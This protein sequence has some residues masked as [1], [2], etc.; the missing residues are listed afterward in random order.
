MGSLTMLGRYELIAE[1]GKGAMGVVYKAQDPLLSRT[2]AIKTINMDEAEH[3]GLAEFEA[4]LYQE[5]KA[6]GGLNHPNIV[7]VY[8]IGKSGNLVYMAMEYVEGGDLRAMLVEGRPLAIDKILDIGA[9]VAEGLAYAHEH[10]VIHR[11]IKPANIMI[12][13]QGRVK[14]ADFG[15]AR[16]RSSESRT[17]TGV[18]LGSPKYLSPEQV[19]G[20]RVDH[21]ADIFSLGVILYQMITGS[22]PFN[23]ETVSGL[24][25]QVT[26]FDPPAPSTVNPQTPLMLDY[27]VAKALAKTPDSRY[28]SAAELANDLRQCTRWVEAQASGA[29]ISVLAERSRP[30]S[31]RLVESGHPAAAAPTRGVSRLFDSQEATQRL[32]REI[33]DDEVDLDLSFGSQEAAPQRMNEIDKAQTDRH[34]ASAAIAMGALV[35]LHVPVHGEHPWGRRENTIL[36][37]TVVVALAIAA[38]IV[39]A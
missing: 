24:M 1:L 35:P 39:F 19:T 13:P 10:R 33:G 6:A 2:V 29:G 15:I 4:R 27:I 12:T 32:V 14:I 30:P 21:R 20:Q 38:T 25:Y 22:T 31:T 37:V 28:E 36:T 5:A 17:Q 9:Q 26:N 23:G 7:I 3:E 34:P 11:D 16:M 8:D 18:I